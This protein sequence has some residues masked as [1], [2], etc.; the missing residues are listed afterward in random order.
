MIDEGDN[1]N[2]KVNSLLGKVIKSG[3]RKGAAPVSRVIK[4]ELKKY[5]TFAPLLI[6]LIGGLPGPLAS[7]CVVIH[8][9]RK[10]KTRV[11]RSLD[12]DVQDLHIT[13]GQIR[14]WRSSDPKLNLRP[15][16][17]PQL[18][19]R[20]A[21]NWRPL[22]AIADTFGP[23][24]GERAR[25]AAVALT[26]GDFGEDPRITLLRDIRDIFDTRGVGRIASAALVTALN[27]IEDG[28]WS[29]WRGLRDEGQPRKLTQ[30]ELARLLKPFK[31]FG[32]WSRSVWPRQRGP[33][34][35]SAKGYYRHQFESAWA[36]FCSLDGTAAQSSKLRYL[37]SA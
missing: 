6:A 9:R 30:G 29:E 12:D 32:I 13:Y 5:P 18:R 19:N 11:L 16:M 1:L 37:R 10:D 24:W 36:S 14:E 20:D 21:D 15:Q 8:M 33:G 23:E 28:L 3:H 4:G 17:P 2:S 22:V 34:S 35:K 31:P 26:K 7:R 25:R 27:E